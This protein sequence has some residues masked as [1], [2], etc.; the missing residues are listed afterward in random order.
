MLTYCPDL[1]AI[2]F[3]GTEWGT[4][5]EESRG[6]STSTS[7]WTEVCRTRLKFCKESNSPDYFKRKCTNNRAYIIPTTSSDWRLA[8]CSFLL[9][10]TVVWVIWKIFFW[11]FAWTYSQ[12]VEYWWEKVETLKCNTFFIWWLF[13]KSV[14][15]PNLPRWWGKLMG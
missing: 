15:R 8:T 7:D 13:S 12:Y 11:Y 5:V 2:F 4:G 6:V 14:K 9:P 10:I 3:D 1:W